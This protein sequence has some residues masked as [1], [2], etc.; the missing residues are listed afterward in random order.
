[1]NF[2]EPSVRRAM[3]NATSIVNEELDRL[4]HQIRCLKKDNEGLLVKIDVLAAELK[5]E[6]N[7]AASESSKAGASISCMMVFGAAFFLML[8]YLVFN[9]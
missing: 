6:R 8:G 2:N 3:I 5:Y 1:M 9:I 4:N 7:W